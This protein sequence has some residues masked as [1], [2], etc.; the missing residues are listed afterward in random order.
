M[1]IDNFENKNL[2]F[3]SQIVCKIVQNFSIVVSL[4]KQRKPRKITISFIL[5]DKGFKGTLLNHLKLH[6][7]SLKLRN[8][9]IATWFRLS[10]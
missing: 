9:D 1:N 7:Q 2:C 6:L 3:I 5:L 4:Q 10:L 8:K